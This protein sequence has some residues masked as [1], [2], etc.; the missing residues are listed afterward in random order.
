MSFLSK[1]LGHNRTEAKAPESEV[2]PAT[3]E[4]PTE[5]S[6]SKSKVPAQGKVRWL[7]CD[8]IYATE[9][10]GEQYHRENLERLCGPDTGTDDLRTPAHLIPEDDNP[11][12]AN[13]VPRRD[14]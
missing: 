11:Y 12:D 3:P 7:T 1:L 14:K 13:T 8:G 9:V 6:A 10:V 5:P 4:R 2:P